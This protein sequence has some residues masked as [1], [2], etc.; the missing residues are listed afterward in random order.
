MILVMILLVVI[1]GCSNSGEVK[2]DEDDSLNVNVASENDAGSDDDWCNEGSV[3]DVSDSSGAY[4]FEV[5]GI[6]ESG[7]YEGMC[8]SRYVV[9]SEGDSGVMDYYVDEDGN[10]FQVMTMNGETTKIQWS[11]DN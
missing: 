3:V 4:R 10:G 6:V 5:L 9:D 7:E 1:G 11:N 2:V 8:H